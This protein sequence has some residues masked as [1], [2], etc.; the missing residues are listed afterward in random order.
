MKSVVL[1]VLGIALALSPA[2]ADDDN[3]NGKGFQVIPSVFDPF[4]THLVAA[5]WISGIGCPFQPGHGLV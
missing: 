3:N 4:N 2:F 1:S 5:G